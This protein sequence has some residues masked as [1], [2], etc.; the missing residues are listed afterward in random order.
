[1]KAVERRFDVLI[2]DDS[3]G[4]D[5]R[6]HLSHRFFQRILAETNDP[7]SNGTCE[8]A[9]D[10]PLQYLETDFGKIQGDNPSSNRIRC[11]L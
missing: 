3:I 8:R 4:H 2:Q 11:T 9:Y 5:L 1:M 7:G 6:D 10:G